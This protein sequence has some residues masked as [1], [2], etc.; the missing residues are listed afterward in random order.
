MPAPYSYD[1]GKKSDSRGE[2]RRSKKDMSQMWLNI[3]GNTLDWWLKREEKTGDYR[4]IT[5]YQQGGQHKIMDWQG[6]GEFPR[7][8]GGNTQAERAFLMGRQSNSA[9]S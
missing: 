9:E 8:H 2:K 1:M 5:N 4:A 3:S 6:F 7:E